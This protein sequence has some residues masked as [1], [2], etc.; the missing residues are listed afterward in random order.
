MKIQIKLWVY[1]TLA[2]VVF[3]TSYTDA[4]NER[5]DLHMKIMHLVHP[6]IQETTVTHEFSENN[7]WAV[8]G[9][10][11]TELGRVEIAIQV[12]GEDSSIYIFNNAGDEFHFRLN[13]ET[14]LVILISLNLEKRTL[15]FNNLYPFVDDLM[16]D[17]GMQKEVFIRNDIGIA[18]QRIPEDEFSKRITEF[19]AT[20]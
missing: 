8:K 12:F 18:E 3:N 17:E 10:S 13:R 6:L 11:K 4:Q 16:S 2:L 19:F 14:R 1:V 15:R 20:L 9:Y 5:T 7:N